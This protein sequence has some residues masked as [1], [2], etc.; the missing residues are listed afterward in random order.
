MDVRSCSL[1]LLLLLAVS[2]GGEGLEKRH[3][4]RGR[5]RSLFEH[6]RPELSMEKQRYS[7]VEE[8]VQQV[9]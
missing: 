1:S 7:L 2:W 3:A 8:I 5:I 9:S 6:E 4:T